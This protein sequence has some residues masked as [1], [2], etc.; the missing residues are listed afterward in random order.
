MLDFTNL[1]E[2]VSQI[3]KSYFYILLSCSLAPH[4]S[5][6]YTKFKFDVKNV[7]AS[8]ENKKVSRKLWQKKS[9]QD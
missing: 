9:K 6:T 8:L 4:T 7:K 5:V 3:K 1:T 2:N